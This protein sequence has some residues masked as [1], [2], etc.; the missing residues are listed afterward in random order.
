MHDDKQHTDA[1]GEAETRADA[2]RWRALAARDAAERATTEY[3]RRAQERVANMH[4]ELALIH[5]DHAR[6]LRRAGDRGEP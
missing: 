5:D 3:A 4:S 6:A 2:A 1:A